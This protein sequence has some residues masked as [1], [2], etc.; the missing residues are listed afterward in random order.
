[1][2]KRIGLLVLLIW[3]IGANAVLAQVE[4]IDLED[5]AQQLVRPGWEEPA[6]QQDE[7]TIIYSLRLV[8]LSLDVDKILK[9]AVELSV[10]EASEGGYTLITDQ[11][12]LSWVGAYP[13]SFTGDMA[14]QW[15]RSLSGSGCETRLATIG[16]RS[17][18]AELTAD[19]I[20]GS[21]EEMELDQGLKISLKP[22][23]VYGLDRRVL[24]DVSVE[25]LS[26]TGAFAEARMIAPIG[27]EAYQ[28]LA[29]VMQEVQRNR[30]WS[31]RCF[32]L[33]ATAT[34]T[35]S[36][37]LPPKGPLVSIGSIKGLQELLTISQ[38]S[39]AHWTK[40]SVGLGRLHEEIGFRAGVELERAEY[41][42][43]VL[44]DGSK[45][46]YGYRLG[47]DWRLYEELGLAVHTVQRPGLN[48]VFRLGLS[49]QVH[50]GTLKLEASY[51]PITFAAE[52]GSLIDSSWAL[53][54]ARIEPNDWILRY[55]CIYDAGQVGHEVGVMKQLSSHFDLGL[56]WTRLPTGEDYSGIGLVFWM[57]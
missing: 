55:E 21:E 31:K 4:T 39:K 51:L 44:L 3:L 30:Q 35:D 54:S 6:L 20:T 40:F 2:W 1:M 5:A 15:E 18:W 25:Y 47:A 24:T 53:F 11:A 17:V 32:A 19:R 28:P 52:E 43:C 33:Y 10:N 27:S 41:R 37:F 36:C 8:E 14:G 38:P 23:Q 34:V 13:T 12:I 16:E 49:D 9:A 56:I 7:P 48:P 29:L 57:D 50:W 22:H 46:G 26:I 45:S 42:V